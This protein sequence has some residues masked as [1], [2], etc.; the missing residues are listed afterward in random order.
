ME[1]RTQS[2]CCHLEGNQWPRAKIIEV[3]NAGTGLLPEQTVS[4][5]CRLN[6]PEDGTSTWTGSRR[7]CPGPP[8]RGV[9]ERYGS[10]VFIGEREFISENARTG[11]SRRFPISIASNRARSAT[12]HY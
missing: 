12:S 11:P 10:H 6:L 7:R 2:A 3:T 8:I 1:G 9:A 4:E 5:S